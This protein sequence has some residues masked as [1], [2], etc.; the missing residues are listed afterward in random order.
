MRTDRSAFII[1]RPDTLSQK[2]YDILRQAIR[3]GALVQNTFYSEGELARSM[4]ISRTP[5]REAVIELARERMIDIV[6]QRGFRLRELNAA[7]R[8]EVFELRRV[9][10]SY[11]VRKLA[12]QAT[13]EQI[14]RLRAVLREQEEVIGDAT[15]FLTI[16]EQFHLLMPRMVGLER[17]HDMMVSLRGALWLIGSTALMLD[18]RV[19]LVLA[20]HR[21]IMDAIEVGDGEAAVRAMTDHL[22]ATAQ[23]S[24]AYLQDGTSH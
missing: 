22:S 12:R 24:E 11:I 23:A 19:Q 18:S 21:A 1:D 15:E 14:A 6:P 9:L 3:S 10:E 5:V 13:A 7:E 2:A 16:D 4:G 8:Q 17:T 20:E